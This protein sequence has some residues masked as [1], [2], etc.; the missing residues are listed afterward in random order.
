MRTQYKYS[1][2]I[3]STLFD[4]VY[5]SLRVIPQSTQNQNNLI[6]CQ[7]CPEGLHVDSC[8]Y[9]YCPCSSTLLNMINP[10]FCMNNSSHIRFCRNTSL[11]PIDWLVLA[12]SS[13]IGASRRSL[14]SPTRYLP[15]LE[16]PAQLPRPVSIPGSGNWRASNVAVGCRT[17]AEASHF[18]ASGK[19]GGT[20][21]RHPYLASSWL[22]DKGYTQRTRI[23][24][25]QHRLDPLQ[26]PEE[27]GYL[28]GLHCLTVP[29]IP[30]FW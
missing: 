2:P 22:P 28:G 25:R 19:I 26:L 5:V 16:D 18:S 4:V 29:V 1:Y 6:H 12:P 24:Q 8:I 27:L 11:A 30:S 13:C 10:C 14:L 9:R 17:L 7:T 20:A 21:T 23:L 15:G 3:F